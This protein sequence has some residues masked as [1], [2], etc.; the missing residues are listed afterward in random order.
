[1]TRL[2]PLTLLYLFIATDASAGGWLQKE[3]PGREPFQLEV[4][5]LPPGGIVTVEYSAE[6]PRQ[7]GVRTE[8][9]CQSFDAKIPVWSGR[10]C[11][12][13]AVHMF[14]RYPVAG[15]AATVFRALE[16]PGEYTAIGGSIGGQPFRFT[17][18]EPGYAV[19]A[20]QLPDS[21]IVSV[22]SK[23]PDVGITSNETA[24]YRAAVHDP[25]SWFSE[26][27]LDKAPLAYTSADNELIVD[28]TRPVLDTSPWFRCRQTVLMD[29]SPKLAKYWGGL[30][31]YRGEAVTGKTSRCVGAQA[32]DAGKRIR[33]ANVLVDGQITLIVTEI[34]TDPGTTHERLIITDS[35]QVLFYQHWL[36]PRDAP[37]AMKGFRH[38]IPGL[39]RA[40]PD[41]AIPPSPAYAAKMKKEY[42]RLFDAML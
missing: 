40:Y 41:F 22:R 4:A 9:S 12:Q 27:F 8:K 35:N 32:A 24:G 25:E 37:Y 28:R 14:K 31:D 5:P 7:E 6:K 11:E 10:H 18:R 13:V 39:E 34:E 20:I 1:M 23:H 3:R 42:R 15:G 30:N 16:G 33:R 21:V 19:A 29:H 17:S 26:L 2:F 38:W 36:A